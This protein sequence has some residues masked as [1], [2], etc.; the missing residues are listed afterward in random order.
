MHGES[1]DMDE[2]GMEAGRQAE[3]ERSFVYC[4]CGC[5]ERVYKN[6]WGRQGKFILGHQVKKRSDSS[7]KRIYE[8]F[9]SSL[10][11]CACGC[12][13]KVRPRHGDTLGQFIKSRGSLSH[14]KYLIGHSRR[15]PGWGSDLSYDQR[16]AILGTLLGD[17]SILY[18]NKSSNAPRLSFNHGQRQ[19]AWARH[20]AEFLST[21]GG[22][23][24]V[25]KNDGYGSIHYRFTSGCSES[26]AEIHK[27]VAPDGKKAV[28]REWL[29]GVGGIGLAWWICDD[30]ACSGNGATL[31]TE[32]FSDTEQEIISGWFRDNYGKASVVSGGRGHKKISISAD[33]QR[34]ILPIVERHVPECMQY[35]LDS[36]RRCAKSR[37]YRKSI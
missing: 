5:G 34:C 37:V 30:G 27:I 3:Q 29:D 12:G 7:W 35:K 14:Y 28:T 16:S 9:I 8:E 32:G 21:L 6:K 2:I 11:E 31:H 20:K 33:A 25:A 4:S 13:N 26:L 36:Y 18:P 24:V 10:P 1:Q 19:E 23:V 22:R 17:S 15:G